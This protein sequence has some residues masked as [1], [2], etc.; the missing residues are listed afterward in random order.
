VPVQEVRLGQT[1]QS[2]LRKLHL[3]EGFAS[4]LD[5]RPTRTDPPLWTGD[6]LG[7]PINGEVGEVVVSTEAQIL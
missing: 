7:F 2:R 5:R 6:R 4:I 3:H 1:L